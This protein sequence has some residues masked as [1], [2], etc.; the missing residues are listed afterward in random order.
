[1]AD[2]LA[3]SALAI[4]ATAAGATPPGEGGGKNAPAAKAAIKRT[5]R[6]C[7][8]CSQRKVKVRPRI[9]R[10]RCNLFHIIC[11]FTTM[12]Y[13]NTPLKPLFLLARL[14][15]TRHQFMSFPFLVSRRRCIPFHS[16]NTRHQCIL[17]HGRRFM[18]YLRFLDIAM[19]AS[20]SQIHDTDVFNFEPGIFFTTD[21]FFTLQDSRHQCILLRTY[22]HISGFTTPVYSIT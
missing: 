11:I 4:A 5:A 21:S 14:S 17:F 15:H 8:L 16:C 13:S 10:H 20:F 2:Q 12:V 3:A 19:S 18:S 1:M 22:C 6:A 7:D 9:S